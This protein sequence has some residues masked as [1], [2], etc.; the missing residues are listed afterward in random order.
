MTSS[1]TSTQTG[2]PAAA[3]PGEVG[4]VSSR[5]RRFPIWI[6][7]AI[8]GVLVVT[9]GVWAAKAWR[10]SV[11]RVGL[12][13][14]FE[15]NPRSFSVVLREKGEL[16]AAQSTEI[17]CRVEGRSTIISLIPEGTAVQKGDLLVELASN[18][19][20]DRIKQDQLKESNAITAFEAAK[21]EL[22]IQ[23]DKNDSDIRKAKLEIE[24]NQLALDKYVKGDWLQTIKD[25]DIAIQQAEINL[26]RETEDYEAAQ[27]LYKR[28]FITK[29]EFWDD[30]FNHTRAGW[31]L[32]KAK[33]AKSVLEAYTHVADLRRRESD[34]EEA[35]K[36]FGRVEKNASAEALKK[37]R[38]AEGKE[39]ELGLIR[40]QLA[41]LRRQKEKSRITAPTQGFV[42]YYSGG[43]RHFMSS[44]TQIREG[45]TVYERQ[46][47]MT[48]PDTTEM[49][50]IVRV[51]EAKTDKLK[52]GQRANVHIEGIPNQEFSGTV[53]KIAVVADT[54]NR[55]L[56]PDLKEYETE[57]TLDHTEIPLKPGVTAHAQILVE[58]V[59]DKLA[60]PV[61]AVYSKTGRRYVFKT[62]GDS[63]EPLE[64]E[65][66]AIGSEWAEITKGANA[67]NRILL[68]FGDEHKRLIPDLPMA[69]A[70]QR[71]SSK[72]PQMGARSRGDSKRPTH[73]T[74]Q[75]K[76]KS[77]RPPNAKYGKR[78]TGTK[79]ATRR[80][81]P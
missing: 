14:S 71:T 31:D 32:E 62:G 43:G 27:K 35:T 12:V 77:K 40:D 41:K 19:I 56:N 11:N 20:D 34:L 60:V 28:N 63:V 25:A 39:T 80:S 22:E 17:V 5:A 2:S 23:K 78:P 44:D 18:E 79:A 76:A 6:A 55:W 74:D 65:L 13:E 4:G 15:I 37:T 54:Q 30:E 53:T 72:R 68:A 51:H 48:L 75:D 7:I 50:V 49:L 64:V 3:M 16:K 67:G 8:V 59:T 70:G 57:I 61:Q 66:G 36:E 29:T 47:I 24:L 69:G 52:L 26:Q 33:Q 38:W 10:Q 46:I 81:T 45:A 58:T 9:S 21:T 42:V 73:A 1:L